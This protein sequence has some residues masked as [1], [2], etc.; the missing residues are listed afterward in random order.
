MMMIDD[1]V[2]DWLSEENVATKNNNKMEGEIDEFQ[3]MK[4]GK[5]R[6]K[7]MIFIFWTLDWNDARRWQTASRRRHLH[8]QCPLRCRRRETCKKMRE[9]KF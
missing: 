8:H 2:F 7:R 3:Q 4:N 1:D 6:K 9:N 5:E